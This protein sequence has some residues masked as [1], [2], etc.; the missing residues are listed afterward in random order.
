MSEIGLLMRVRECPQE[1]PLGKLRTTGTH[2]SLSSRPLLTWR[3]HEL[4][5]S[6]DSTYVGRGLEVVDVL[7]KASVANAA[8][9]SDEDG[10]RNA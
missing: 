7:P 9:D 6:V 1:D 8:D 3:R 5:A 4:L 10:D 2:L